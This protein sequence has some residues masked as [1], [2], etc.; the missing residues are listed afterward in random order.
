MYYATKD[1]YINI[2]NDIIWH[3]YNEEE[4]TDESKEV[5][6]VYSSHANF[7]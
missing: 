3:N 2:T 6:E 7:I 1:E 5:L 4:L